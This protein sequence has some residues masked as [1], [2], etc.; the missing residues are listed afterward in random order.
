MIILEAGGG[1]ARLLDVRNQWLSRV[2]AE[3]GRMEVETRRRAKEEDNG[4]LVHGEKL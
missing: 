3:P 4:G 1:E 2:E